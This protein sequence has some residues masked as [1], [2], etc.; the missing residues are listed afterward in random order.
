MSD[1][2]GADMPP[3]TLLSRAS[4]SVSRL[5]DGG[6]MAQAAIQCLASPLPE[7]G[8]RST[9]TVRSMFSSDLTVDEAILLGE[10]GWQPRRLVMGSSIFHVGYVTSNAPRT[11]G[12]MQEGELDAVS[13]AMSDA[14][15]LAINRL[16]K[17]GRE[18]GADAVVGV[19]LS[20]SLHRGGGHAAQFSAVGTAIAN[21]D[22]AARHRAANIDWFV[23]TD[24][25]GQDFYLLDRA[26]YEP[27]GLVFGSCVYY[28]PPN[29][30]SVSRTNVELDAPTRALSRA[31]ELAMARMQYEGERLGAA[32]IVGVKVSERAHAWWRNSIEFLAIGTAVRPKHDRDGTPGEHLP[33]E[34]RPVVD[35]ADDI[36]LTDPSSITGHTGE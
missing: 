36:S 26:G 11:G 23:T 18:A 9:R 7:H 24:L 15:H 33:L 2:P 25:S 22:A 17:D 31:R 35:L 10:T 14:R 20:V 12:R 6:P 21:S 3:Q 16:I 32:G 4:T 8:G 27:L 34:V 30:A 1:T 19:R 13:R 5:A 29:W 28:C